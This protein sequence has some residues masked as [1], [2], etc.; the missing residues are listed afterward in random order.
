M[1]ILVVHVEVVG[2]LHVLIGEK[3]LLIACLHLIVLRLYLLVKI[4]GRVFLIPI[5][6]KIS[7]RHI[8]MVMAVKRDM[9]LLF[10]GR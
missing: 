10:L 5:G 4:S 6:R 3:V 1:L 8:M 7:R 2:V 9:L